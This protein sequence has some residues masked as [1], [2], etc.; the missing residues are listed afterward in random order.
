MQRQKLSELFTDILVI[1]GMAVVA[2][3]AGMAY[4]PAGVIVGG[5][6]LILLGIARGW[7][8]Q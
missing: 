4:V 8:E 6:E 1:L 2:V 7:T 5:L 3:G